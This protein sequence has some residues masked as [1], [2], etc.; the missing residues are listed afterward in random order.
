MSLV[1]SIYA[2]T[3]SIVQVGDR[4]SDFEVKAW[5]TSGISAEPSLLIIVL[6]ALSQ[7]FR[8]KVLVVTVC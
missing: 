7:E 8:T 4:F 5:G 3:R 1:H 6:E 2:N